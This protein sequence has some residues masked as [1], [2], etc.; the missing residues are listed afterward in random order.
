MEAARKIG[1]EL[2]S[3]YKQHDEWYELD[4]QPAQAAPPEHQLT[5]LARVNEATYE[6]GTMGD[7][8]PMI[9]YQYFGPRRVPVFSTLLG[10]FAEHYDLDSTRRILTAGLK[11]I[12]GQTPAPG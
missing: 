2:P 4:R 8:H 11:F 5:V 9:W 10:H 12:L 6:G 7:D 1:L 3:E